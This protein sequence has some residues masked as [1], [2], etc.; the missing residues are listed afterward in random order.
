MVFGA[1]LGGIA[2]GLVGASGSR[3]AGRAQERAANTSAQ[4][5]REGLE[6]FRELTDPFREAGQAAINPLLAALGITRIPIESPIGLPQGQ[7]IESEFTD[8]TDPKIF[9]KGAGLGLPGSRLPGRE[10]LFPAPIDTGESNNVTEQQYEYVQNALPEIGLDANI[11]QHPLLQ[12]IQ[13]ETTQR[14]ID[15]TAGQGRTGSLPG[16]LATALA[17]PALNL[18]LSQQASKISER[19]QN[20]NNLFNLLGLGSN[21]A[22]GAGTASQNT[23]ANVGQSILAGGQAAAQSALG[24]AQAIQGGIGD[25]VGLGLLSQGGFF[26]QPQ[27][28]TGELHGGFGGFRPTLQTQGPLQQSGFF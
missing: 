25:A 28:F 21:V 6:Q 12:A 18:A 22:V 5:Q 3:S 9:L 26:Q 27:Q 11:M 24:Q 14:V 17:G 8:V 20:I 16:Q 1:I 15:Q 13:N 7:T 2:T 19:Q 10:T 4:V 23:A